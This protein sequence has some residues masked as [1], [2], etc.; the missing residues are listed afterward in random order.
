MFPPQDGKYY[1]YLRR[2]QQDAEY[3]Q[4]GQFEVLARHER[5]INDMASDY[6]HTIL[7]TFKEVVSGE[8]IAARDEF[9]KVL[10]L[11]ANRECD[12]IYAVEASR[13]GRG[14]G[15][16]QDTIVAA[17]ECNGIWLITDGK[18]YN[19][20]S[21]SD[22]KL[23]RQELRRATD[24]RDD[25][26]NR[27]QRGRRQAVRDGCFM[28]PVP[29][30]WQKVRIGTKWTLE[31]HPVNYERM[32]LIY[33]MLDD[34]ASFNQI[35][36]HFEKMGYP[37]SHRAKE[38]CG[39]AIKQIAQNPVNIGYVR[40][41]QLTTEK[42]MNPETFEVEKVRVKSDDY[43]MVEGLHAHHCTLSKEKFERV[44]LKVQAR[45]PYS[46]VYGKPL[47]NPLAGLIRCSKCRM[48]LKWNWVKDMNP[49]CAIYTHD[50][51][52]K[53]RGCNCK[54][55]HEDEL[56]SMIVESLEAVKS[57]KTIELDN[58]MSERRERILR[59]IKSCEKS[60]DD[61]HEEKKRVM[62]GYRQ[63]VY[64]DEEFVGQKA[65]VD[66][67]IEAIEGR[68]VQLNESVPSEDTVKSEILTIS[69][70]I[71]IF[72]SDATPKEMNDALKMFIK[73]IRYTNYAPPKKQ[74]NDVHLEI[75]WV[76]PMSE[77]FL[78]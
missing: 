13:L 73:E 59:E 31:P 67:K 61:A 41:G 43:I 69:E 19:P 62:R 57:E 9:K 11:M 70:C 56:I 74:W 14:G 58:G 75:I 12:G 32:M 1:A 34:G 21:K 52:G 45:S 28:G 50:E 46:T 20:N 54:S 23:L 60:L 18:I 68:I 22:M 77:N 10:R 30:G 42:Q 76:N 6:G 64:T 2:S 25:S 37:T 8:T 78:S 48:T 29:Y 53:R 63:G 44:Q 24:E 7:H 39:T 5:I 65:E 35:A 36:N 17:F 40:F 47:R 55:I 38:W 71:D 72:R 4:Y 66:R 16:D 49:P 15:S 33:D 27:M 26:N 3:E 51:L